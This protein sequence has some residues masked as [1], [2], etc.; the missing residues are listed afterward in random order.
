MQVQHAQGHAQNNQRPA[1]SVLRMIFYPCELKKVTMPRTLYLRSA[2]HGGSD[3]H[4][5]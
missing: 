5:L 3:V 4:V 2:V 1:Q